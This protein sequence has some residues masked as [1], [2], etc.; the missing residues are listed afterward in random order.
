MQ[1]SNFGCL[2]LALWF[3]AYNAFLYV[4]LKLYKQFYSD[5]TTFLIGSYNLRCLFLKCAARAFIVGTRVSENIKDGYH[6][7]EWVSSDHWKIE[8]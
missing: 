6:G 8:F 5:N 7:L 3:C 4:H 2:D 1:P